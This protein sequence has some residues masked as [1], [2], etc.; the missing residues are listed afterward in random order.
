MDVITNGPRPAS[1]PPSPPAE[2]RA[3]EA[4]FQQ[5]VLQKAKEEQETMDR[6]FPKWAAER[7]RRAALFGP[8]RA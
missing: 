6:Q 1:P 4:Q 5:Y 7:K 2:M 3:E 8:K